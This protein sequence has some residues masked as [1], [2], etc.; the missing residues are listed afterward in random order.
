MEN[1]RYYKV[2]NSQMVYY[3]LRMVHMVRLKFLLG[4]IQKHIMEKKLLKDYFLNNQYHFL[5]GNQEE[6]QKDMQVEEEREI[7]EKFELYFCL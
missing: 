4:L 6:F 1:G 3:K 2:T 7:P 5:S